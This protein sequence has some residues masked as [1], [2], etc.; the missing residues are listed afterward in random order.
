ML[1]VVDSLL[2]FSVF[3]EWVIIWLWFRFLEWYSMLLVVCSRF[4]MLVKCL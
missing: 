2:W 1:V 4:W 3:G